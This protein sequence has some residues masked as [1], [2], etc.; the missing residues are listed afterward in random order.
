MR[1]V[2]LCLTILLAGC[3]SG[4]DIANTWIGNNVNDL[5]A[6]WGPP[7]Q[8]FDN[9]PSGRIMVWVSRGSVTF[10]GTA[11]DLGGT[12]YYNPGSTI[13]LENVTTMWVDS[14][15]TIYRAGCTERHR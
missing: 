15:G 12:T 3:Q 5:I 14:S 11:T 9:G 8:V 1:N 2:L 7:E 6:A 13:P 4:Q 10:P